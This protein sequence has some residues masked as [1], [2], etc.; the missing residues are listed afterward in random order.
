MIKPSRPWSKGRE[1]FSGASLRVLR[2]RMAQKPPTPSS[3][4]A[5]SAPPASMM[6]A[7]P[8]RIMRMDSPRQWVPV[9]QAEVMQKLGPCRPYSMATWPARILV[10]I[11]GIIKGEKRDGP[12]VRSTSIC[13]MTTCR[14]PM[15][16]PIS[17]PQRVGFSLLKS[18][19]E[20]CTA[21]RVAPSP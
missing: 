12:L 13:S 7:S 4:M 2:A 17:T 5:P 11:C 9:A 15:P 14:P 16:E 6:S 20:S 18:S 8:L 10:I 1:A 3:Q 19:P 21:R